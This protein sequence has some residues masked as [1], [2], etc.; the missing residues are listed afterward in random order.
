MLVLTEAAAFLE[1]KILDAQIDAQ[2]KAQF[3]PRGVRRGSR[4]RALWLFPVA[5]SS[6]SRRST[7]R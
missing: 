6:S 5:N 1:D 4:R 3:S 2:G 7:T